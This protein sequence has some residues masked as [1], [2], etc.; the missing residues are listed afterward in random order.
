MSWRHIASHCPV[1]PMDNSNIDIVPFE[2]QHWPEVAEIFSQGIATENAT[3]ETAVPDLPTFLHRFHPGLLWVGLKRRQVTGW[4]GLRPFSTKKVYAG[5]CEVS[6]YVHAD[7]RGMGI[8]KTL[9]H[10]LVDESE[11]AGM[12]TLFASVFPENAASISLHRA[13]G[14]REIGYRE[15]VGKLNGVWRNTVQF[16]RRSKINGL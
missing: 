11:K 3:F 5:V 8:G 4:A 14:F 2:K 16:E 13:L 9:L 10:H 6:V 1:T 7:H 15:R 12:W